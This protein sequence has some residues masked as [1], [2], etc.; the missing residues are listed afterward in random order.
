[1]RSC[2]QCKNA[3]I[4]AG[5]AGFAKPN[6]DKFSSNEKTIDEICGSFGMYSGGF[7]G[8]S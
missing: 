5:D 1:M 3:P 7:S 2:V 6:A 8:N 4:I